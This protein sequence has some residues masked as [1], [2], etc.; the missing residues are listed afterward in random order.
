ML[1][2]TSST[3][4]MSMPSARCTLRSTPCCGR[5]N[6]ARHSASPSAPTSTGQRDRCHG[7]ARSPTPRN[8]AADDTVSDGGRRTSAQTAAAT[9]GSSNSAYQGC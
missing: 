8:G 1:G 6:A 3:S 4:M 2:D 7:P 9:S 5:I